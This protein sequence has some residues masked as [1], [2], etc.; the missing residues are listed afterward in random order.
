MNNTTK[1]KI[2]AVVFA[3]G[4]GN[5]MINLTEQIEKPLLLIGNMPL[6]WYPLN[7]L[8]RNS[9]SGKFYNKNFT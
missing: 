5:R 8:S 9:I 2:Q 6:F 1:S 4:H 3:G 7:M